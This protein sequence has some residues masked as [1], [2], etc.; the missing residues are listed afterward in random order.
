MATNTNITLS[1]VPHR[2]M[3]IN[4][5]SKA[6]TYTRNTSVSVGTSGTSILAINT[7]RKTATFVNDSDETI[8]LFLSDDAPSTGQGIRLNA[9]GGS[10]EINVTNLYNGAITAICAS[11]GKNLCVTEGYDGIRST[12][13]I[14]SDGWVFKEATKTINSNYHLRELAQTSTIASDSYIKKLGTSKTLN[15]DSYIKKIGNTKTLNSNAWVGETQSKTINSNAHILKVTS[16][17]IVSDMFLGYTGQQPPAI[18]G[19]AYITE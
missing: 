12:T 3:D 17:T 10:Y 13:T 7:S 6:L 14:N 18:F 4:I 2:A 8:Y 19:W 15:S 9:E 1:K 5:L 11:G 16:Q